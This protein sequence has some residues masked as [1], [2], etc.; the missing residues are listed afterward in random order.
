[1]FIAHLHFIKQRT[2]LIA[3][4]SLQTGYECLLNLI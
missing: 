2:S 3:Y 1:M 4:Y